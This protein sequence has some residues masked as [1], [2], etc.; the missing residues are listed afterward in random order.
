M[1][2]LTGA[3][4]AGKY[5]LLRLIGRGAMGAVWEA[6]VLSTHKRCALKLLLTPELAGDDQVL[7]RFFREARASGLIQSQHVVTAFDS[8]VDPAGHAFYVMEYLAGED[9]E[10][11]LRRLGPLNPTAATKIVFQAALGLA[12]AHELGI[13]HRDVKPANLFL[14]ASD[15][16]EVRVMVLDF[17][18]AK[19]KM[20]VFNETSPNM[21]QTRSMLGTPLYMSPEQAMRASAI[22]ASADVW[23]LG[24]VLFECLTGTS[25]WGEVESIAE[26]MAVILTTHLPLLQDHAPWVKPDLADIA[27][28]AMS[29]DVGHRYR[30][31]AEL[32]DALKTV[33]PD[34]ARLSQAEIGPPEDSERRSIAPRLS[35]ADT[36]M[37]RPT[38]RP[39]V[40]T[41]GTRVTNA[42]LLN[43]TRIALLVL[44]LALGTGAWKFAQRSH[45]DTPMLLPPPPAPFATTSSSTTPLAQFQLEIVPAEAQVTVDGHA[46]STRGG[47]LELAGPLGATHIVHLTSQGQS[48]EERVAITAE[49]LI[50]S[51]LVLPV[52]VPARAKKLNNSTP[53]APRKPTHSAPSPARDATPSAPAIQP[54]SLSPEFN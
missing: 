51:K 40:G 42:G 27:H 5:E 16:G 38:F 48:L 13:V 10:Q 17:G 30:N 34:G 37:L 31:A 14:A 47:Q 12:K 44:V 8:G 53:D 36:V 21:T 23:S 1:D 11:A 52:P 24:V 3:V 20:E 49:G 41:D 25:P 15:D 50:P 19:V 43:R 7:K 33:L 6:K 46:V 26:L 54:P 29:R 2:D 45:P 32:R 28:R 9:L 39:R 4:I 35:L 22:D 18:V